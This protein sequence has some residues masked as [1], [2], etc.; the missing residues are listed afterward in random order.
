MQNLSKYTVKRIFLF[1][2]IYLPIQYMLIGIAG[3]VGSEP[4]PTFAL[5]GFKKVA[6]TG[7]QI[8][9]VK[10]LFFVEMYSD[11][12]TEIEVSP[13]ELF[14]GLQPSQVTGIYTNQLFAV[15]PIFPRRKGMAARAVTDGRA[16]ISDPEKL[17]VSM[18]KYR[19]LLERTDKII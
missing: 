9:V 19:L 7:Q 14:E 13:E 1:F 2:L 15:H 3:I 8:Q 18:G 17:T 5:P 6:T 10:P 11:K 4:W 12:G 16:W